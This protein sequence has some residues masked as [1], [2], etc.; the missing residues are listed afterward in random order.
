M[1]LE[2]TD[3]EK[4]VIN[5]KAA[6][7]VDLFVGKYAKIL[8]AVVA[9][10]VVALIVFGIVSTVN[11]RNSERIY[12]ELLSLENDFNTNIAYADSTSEGYQGNVDAFIERANIFIGAN[13]P[14]SYAG[15]K[16]TML[17]ADTYFLEEDWQNAYDNYQRVADSHNGDYLG[18]VA[19]INAAAALENMGDTDAA[20]DAYSSLFD[21][22]GSSS[23]LAPRALFNQARI[24]ESRDTE[25]ARSIYEQLTTEFPS[26]SYSALA[27]SR[28]L[29]L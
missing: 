17:L 13:D 1:K 4:L 8:I 6:R 20:Y 27:A 21:V 29:T 19:L 10:V 16:A 24:E 3:G 23:P 9:V 28:L 12:S 7:H 5:E 22:Y 2:H 26:S 25:V 15:A 18:S 14:S 11:S